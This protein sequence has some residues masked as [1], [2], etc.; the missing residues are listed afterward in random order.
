M[1]TYPRESVE[2]VPVTVTVDG[3]ATTAGVTLALT[4]DRARPTTWSA[5]TVI[6]PASGWL[7]DGTLTPGL[8]RL[9]ARVSS[10]PETPVVEVGTITIT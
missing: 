10:A 5:P 1:S 8:Y 2:L 4:T 9:W 7:L 3:V 6:G